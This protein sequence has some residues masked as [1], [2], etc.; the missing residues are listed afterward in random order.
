M[1]TINDKFEYISIAMDN[2][3]LSEEMLDKL[4]ADD[5]AVQKWYE[6]HLISDCM[7][8]Q[9]VGRDADFM[10][11]EHFAAALAEI[12][13]EHQSAYAEKAAKSVSEQ[14][15]ANSAFKGFA[16]A[17]SL[18]AVAVSVW[19]FWPQAGDAQMPVAAEQVQP[20]ADQNIV[21]VKAVEPEKKSASDV[22]VP[23]AAKQL[24][25]SERTTAVRTEKQTNPAATQQ[26][27][28]Q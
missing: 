13:H 24:P 19:Q 25:S 20:A 15:A 2:E 12:S 28:V 5:A 1:T 10:Q 8:E 17:A 4:L 11:S 18:A 16:V 9:T 6:Y 3:D 7:K 26:E 21:L 22:V 23:D 14:K 27:V